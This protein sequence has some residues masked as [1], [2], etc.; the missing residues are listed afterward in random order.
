MPRMSAFLHTFFLYT[1]QLRI[2]AV[3]LLLLAPHVA[4][5]AEIAVTL[6]PLAG[7]IHMLD[8]KAD[9]LCL[10]GKGSDPHHF[11][12]TARKIEATAQTKLLIRA[13]KDD[14]GWPLPPHHA[15]SLDLWPDI[16]HGWLNP[17]TVRQA[18]P[19]IAKALI[20]LQPQRQAAIAT[21]LQQAL[22]QTEA[23]EA[24][25]SKALEPAKQ[26]GVLM[27]HPSWRRFMQAMGVPILDVLESGHHGHEY[28]PRQLE[29]ALKALN[30]Q[31]QAWIIADSRHNNRALDW[32]QAH[33][34]HKPQRITLN[35][36]SSCTQ[37]WPAFMQQN[38]E[39]LNRF[40][41]PDQINNLNPVTGQKK[42]S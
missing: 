1:L 4:R 38:I 26:A 41:K 2:A 33:A 13:S 10:L 15:H 5:A 7:L 14:G 36:L 17:A 25:W 37:A 9:V 24:A 6:P 42:P 27:Q 16:D 23:I 40:D 19:I 30:A 8:E 29:H 21:A 20:D 3:L 39:Q 12:L 18:L 32:L 28:G 11:Q 34:T 22:R 31:P 35:A